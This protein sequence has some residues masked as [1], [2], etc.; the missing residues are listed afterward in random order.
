MS[1]EFFIRKN[2]TLP[3]LEIDVIKDGTLDY[4]YN[5]TQFSSSTIEFSMKNVDTDI[6]KITN[7]VCVFSTTDYTVSYQFTKRN[8]STVG[9]Y[10]GEFKIVDSQ[11]IVILPLRDKIFINVIDS[12]VDGDF[13]C[14]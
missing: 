13:C 2:S 7:G 5:K 8:T 3:V 1:M 4:N 12:F 9:R 10:V 6:Y 11:G 14:K